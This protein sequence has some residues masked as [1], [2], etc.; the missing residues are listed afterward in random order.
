MEGRGGWGGEDEAAFGPFMGE[1]GGGD[2]EGAVVAGEAGAAEE[3]PV[4]VGGDGKRDGGDGEGV[5]A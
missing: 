5:E 4:G 1:G 3:N 2:D